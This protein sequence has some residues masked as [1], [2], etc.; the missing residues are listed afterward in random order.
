[1][2]YCG[3][4]GYAMEIPAHQVGGSE[5]LWHIRG[6]GLATRGSTVLYLAHVSVQNSRHLQ[7]KSG[8]I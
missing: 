8:F 3:P 4:M 6:Y 2:C 7:T 1:M 5:M